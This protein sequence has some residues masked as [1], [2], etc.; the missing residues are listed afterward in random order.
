M[1]DRIFTEPVAALIA[2]ARAAGFGMFSGTQ[3]KR[4]RLAGLLPDH[5]RIGNRRLFPTGTSRQLLALLTIERDESPATLL[6]VGW[7]AWW[8]GWIVH[9]R[10]WRPV[11]IEAAELWD[12]A[13]PDITRSV[14]D[15]SYEIRDSGF[16][17][18]DKLKTIRYPLKLFRQLRKRLYRCFDSLII[19]VL[20]IA[21]GKFEAFV[22]TTDVDDAI[23][24]DI[25]KDAE[26][27]DRGLGLQRARKDHLPG[28]KPWLSGD[29]TRDL[30]RLSISLRNLSLR[31]LLAETTVDQIQRS[32]DQLIIILSHVAG[33]YETH[34]KRHGIHVFG[35]GV[36][37]KYGRIGFPKIEALLLLLFHTAKRDAKF[38]AD[39]EHL[40]GKILAAKLKDDG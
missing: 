34:K 30:E 5:R 19:F 12:R 25:K 40:V 23:H 10:Y 18:F 4:R 37:S 1:D 28:M 38:S 36:I 35:F 6:K 20:K 2:T 3:L 29:I 31:H 14:F 11:L 13:I 15:S 16:D 17:L 9:E 27:L 21:I 33:V 22:A 24:D 8:F 26:I 7:R 32:R 39:V